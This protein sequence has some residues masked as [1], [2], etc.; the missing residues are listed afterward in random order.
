MI[1]LHII[2]I[3]YKIDDSDKVE[4]YQAYPKNINKISFSFCFSPFIGSGNYLKNSKKHWRKKSI[5]K[6]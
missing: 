6:F 1:I 5:I 2:K 4:K 3:V